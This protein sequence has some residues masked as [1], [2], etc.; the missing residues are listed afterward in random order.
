[1]VVLFVIMLLGLVRMA[2]QPAKDTP[3]SMLEF[4]GQLFFIDY[5]SA[6]VR[7]IIRKD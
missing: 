7:H 4:I 2:V 5:I 1:M 3:T 6:T